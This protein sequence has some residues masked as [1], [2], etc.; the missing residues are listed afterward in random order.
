MEACE[1]ILRFQQQQ[2]CG[3]LL[4][5]SSH[6]SSMWDHASEW[7]SRVWFPALQQT[8]LRYVAWVYSASYYSRM[9][10]DLVI[11]N[12]SQPIVLTF[13]D[14]TTATEWLAQV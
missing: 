8:G 2:R 1:H 12:V 13:D 4:M 10:F 5:D 14:I 7:G 3:K 9:S 6:V 11:K